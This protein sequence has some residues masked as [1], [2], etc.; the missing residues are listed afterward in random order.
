MDASEIFVFAGAGLS[1]PAPTGL[2]VFWQIRDAL[3]RA[4]G[5]PEYTEPRDTAGARTPT[6]KESLAAGLLPEPFLEAM[7]TAPTDT[8]DW[9]RKVLHVEQVNVG[10][11]CVAELLDG[12]SAVWTVNFDEGIEAAAGRKLRVCALEGDPAAPADIYKPHGTLSGRMLFQASEVLAGLPE[13]WLQALRA[14]TAGKTVLLVGY[15]GNDLDFHPVWDD[16]LLDAKQVIWFC[17]ANE[18]DAHRALLRRTNAAAKLYMP[19]ATAVSGR[20]NPTVDFVDWCVRHGLVHFTIEEVD[21]LSQ[22]TTAPTFPAL[23]GNVR[24]ARAAAKEELGD[25]HGAERT[26]LGVAVL[27]PSRGRAVAQLVNVAANHGGRIAA[28]PLSRWAMIPNRPPYT[29]YRNAFHRKYVNVLLNLGRHHDALT[30]VGANPADDPAMEVLRAGALKYVG[31]LAEAAGVAEAAR[32]RLRAAEPP[33]SGLISYAA[34]QLT[35][36]QLWSGDIDAAEHSFLEHYQPYAPL[37]AAR[38]VGW[39]LFLQASI[40]IHRGDPKTGRGA[41]KQLREACRLFDTEGLADGTASCLIALLAAY[42]LTGD[43]IGW[44]VTHKVLVNVINGRHRSGTFYTRRSPVLRANVALEVG[45]HAQFHDYNNDRARRSYRTAAN[46]ASALISAQGL[47]GLAEVESDVAQQ[48]FLLDQA[49][50][51]AH[52]SGAGGLL[53][54]MSQFRRTRRPT[55]RF[56][57]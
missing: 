21:S 44:R 36:A 57:P 45:H 1:R 23:S 13:R 38:W 7:A 50:A 3:L 17:F 46:S 26:L 6:A 14:A 43:Q 20:P 31:N 16:V 12:G 51:K 28:I 54:A 32:A 9:M 55:E 11:R 30:A 41:V 22:P 40:T 15:S 34:L 10:H 52:I 53:S 49:Q 19:P 4:V 37:A 25:H 5:L 56:A 8:A 24:M 27:G 29:R 48:D 39:S 33:Q 47:L 35:L 42:R 2:P 18:Q